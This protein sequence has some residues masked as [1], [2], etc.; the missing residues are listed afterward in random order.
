[1][2]GPGASAADTIPARFRRRLHTLRTEGSGAGREAAAIGTGVFL[3]C[4]PFC[5]LHLFRCWAIGTVLRLPG[6]NSFRT[7]AQWLER[8]ARHGFDVEVKPMG[9]G[10]P[11]ANL[12]FRLTPRRSDTGS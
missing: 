1:M 6:A 10:T 3:G 4:L 12:L 9:A 5:G 2:T 7:R 8:F 11:F